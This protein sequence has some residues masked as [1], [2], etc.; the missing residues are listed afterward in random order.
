MKNTPTTTKMFT[1]GGQMFLNNLRMFLQV[2][3]ALGKYSLW[4][5]LLL[6]VLISWWLM[7]W[8]NIVN[9][10]NYALAKV[11]VLI[12][13]GEASLSVPY[14]G[15]W[16][17][18][19]VSAILSDPYYQRI[20]DQTLGRFVVAGVL[21]FILGLALNIL[22]WRFFVNRG[23]EATA[24]RPIRGPQLATPQQMTRALR[25]EGLGTSD[26]TLDR[27]HFPHA[28]E[29]RHVLLHG[30]TGAG[31]TQALMKFLDTIRRRGDKVILTDSGAVLSQYFYREGQ[32]VMLTPFDARAGFWDLWDESER[33]N[34][35]QTQ[36]ELDN[37]AQALIPLSGREDPFWVN[38]ARNLFASAAMKMRDDPE[39]S[40]TKLLRLLLQE[41][42]AKLNDYFKDTDASMLT[43]KSIRK[44]TTG[45]R[46][47]IAVYL[48]SLRLLDQ[49]NE[50]DQ[51]PFA[52]RRWLLDDS[53]QRWLFLP[54]L[55]KDKRALRPLISLWLDLACLNILHMGEN[56]ERRIWVVLD[57]LSSLNQLPS[58]VNIAETRKFGGCF[59]LGIQNIS[60]LI[61]LYGKDTADELVDMLNTRLFFQSNNH[62]IARWASG[63]L[64]EEELERVVE[65]YSYGAAQVRDG[66][67][68]GR[69]R[70][71]QP[72]ISYSQIQQMKPLEC[73][74]K[75]FGDIPVAHTQLRHEKRRPIANAVIERSTQRDEELDE[76]IHQYEQQYDFLLPELKKAPVDTTLRPHANAT[77]S[78][79]LREEGDK[80]SAPIDKQEVNHQ[81]NQEEQNINPI[82]NEHGHEHYGDKF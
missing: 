17:H 82:A 5:W 23:R 40:I 36:S 65:N 54:Y 42:L 66:I 24:D 56:D 19:S 27:V 31:K 10:F 60:Q 51:S 25:R 16:Y 81:V 59:I 29:V 4:C 58:L 57:E 39:R 21:T 63:Q 1:R 70:L 38:A 26:I 47:I 18:V 73:Y 68:V 72:L 78:P 48:K 74:V 35:L 3:A 30:T 32:D 37:I 75:T 45:I 55:S 13:W 34:L 44:T 22:G 53:D 46:A 8:P 52:I 71:S 50:T 49:A 77:V 62:A 69:Q 80:K 6:M 64:G 12:K 61:K 14:Q 76:L 79:D 41:D 7:G 20:F 67:S 9:S 33:G 11:L 2:N 15:R 28:F 43:D